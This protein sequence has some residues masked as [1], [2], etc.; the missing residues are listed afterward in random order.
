MTVNKIYYSVNYVVAFATIVN[1]QGL[2]GM[3]SFIH[4]LRVLRRSQL[5]GNIGSLK[6]QIFAPSS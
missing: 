4:T 5:A 6:T 1:S 2:L 3:L